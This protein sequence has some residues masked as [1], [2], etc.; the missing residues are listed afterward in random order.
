MK[1]TEN[2]FLKRS[3]YI[4]QY[5]KLEYLLI[6]KVPGS[7]FAHIQWFFLSSRMM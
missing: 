6:F 4:F 3:K 5:E 1:Q 2:N 7:D